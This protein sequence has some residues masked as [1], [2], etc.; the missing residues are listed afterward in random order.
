MSDPLSST[1]ATK[2]PNDWCIIQPIIKPLQEYELA[3]VGPTT[4]RPGDYSISYFVQDT[5]RPK[6]NTLVALPGGWKD[7]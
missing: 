1:D 7:Q 2:K 6:R 5:S 4:S 3:R